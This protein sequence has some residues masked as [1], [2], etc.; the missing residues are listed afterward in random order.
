MSDKGQEWYRRSTEAINYRD[1]LKLV[2]EVLSS[3]EAPEFLKNVAGKAM[4][5]LKAYIEGGMVDS[6]DKHRAD[7]SFASLKIEFG[8][9]K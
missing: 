2:D 4:R 6:I 1:K 9:V 5:N 7:H 8:N 3:D